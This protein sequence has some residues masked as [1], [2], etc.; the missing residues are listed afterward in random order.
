MILGLGTDIT[1]C[2]RIEKMIQRHGDYFLRRILTEREAAEFDG[3][4]Y[5]AGRW[6]AKEALSKAL[7]TGIGSK[8]AFEEIQEN[9]TSCNKYFSAA[10]AGVSPF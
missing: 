9:R 2:T 10:S 6:C 1:D 3:I 7:G 5:L 4:S 8:C